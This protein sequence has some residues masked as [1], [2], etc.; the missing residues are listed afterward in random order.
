MSQKTLRLIGYWAGPS[1]PEVWPDA[2]D[3]LSPAM[4]AE[5]RD[6]VVTYLHSGTVYLAFAGYSVCRVCGI[7]NGTTELTDG[8][9]FVWPSGL[10][11]Y[12]KA[13]DLRLPDEVLA[14]ARRGPAHPVDPFAIERAMLETRELTVDEHW[15]RSRTGSR[16]S[17]PE[18][19]P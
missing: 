5:D 16:G 4:P 10:T 11:H 2:R 14:V 15:W 13:H 7:L 12:V 3:F 9:H 18:R 8:E 17:G 6:A 1:E 19:H